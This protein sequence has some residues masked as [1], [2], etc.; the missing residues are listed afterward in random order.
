MSKSASA[1]QTTLF[2]TGTDTGVGKTYVCS[3]LWRYLLARGVKA[4]YQKWVSTG[5]TGIPDDLRECLAAAGLEVESADLERQAPY[6]FRLPASPHLAA[7]QEGRLIEIENIMAR[8]R[9]LA[10]QYPVLLVEGVGGLLVPLRRDLLLADLLARLRLTT[11]VVA[12]SG[13]G[14][15]NHTLLTLEGLRARQIPI[16][17]VVLSDSSPAEDELIAQDNLRTLEEMGK[18]RVFGRIKHGGAAAAEPVWR[19]IVGALKA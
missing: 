6:R 11:L 15:L 9:E 2:V 3:A 1:G 18:V 13:L 14:T 19:D 4:G 7:E 12:R 8:Y 16:L 17:G 5:G 10:G